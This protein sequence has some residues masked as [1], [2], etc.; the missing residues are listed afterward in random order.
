MRYLVF[1]LAL[2]MSPAFA[3]DYAVVDTSSNVIVNRI[4][5]NAPGDI[6]TPPGQIFV[7]EPAA[8]YDIG[9]T[10]V[11]GVYTAP[12]KP[13]ITIAITT[14]PTSVLLGRLTDAE[15]T[16]IVQAAASQLAA[17]NGQLSRWLDMARTS[18][19]VGLND[20][21]T[22]LAQANLIS[23]GLLTAARVSVIFAP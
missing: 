7:E 1:T 21:P 10:I 23:A 16:A 5:M 22:V 8:G 17:G 14:V 2:A 6:P 13:T 20:T 18:A 11:N 4:V 9:G 3:A 12:V 19:S 15:Y